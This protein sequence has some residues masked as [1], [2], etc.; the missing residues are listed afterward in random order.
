MADHI[1][2]ELAE[3]YLQR[4]TFFWRNARDANFAKLQHYARSASWKTLAWDWDSLGITKT[5]R[6]IA[7]DL[8]FVPTEVL[9]HPEVIAAKPRLFDYYRMLAC[10]SQKGFAQIR[11]KAPK[12]KNDRTLETCRLLNRFLSTLIAAIGRTNRDTLLGTVY[13]EAGSEWQG[14]WVNII[15]KASAI[16]LERIVTDFAE[17][18]Q[19]LEKANT[20][21]HRLALRSGTTITFGSEPDV[22]CRNVKGELLCVIEIKGSADKAGAQT[23]LGETK[24]SFTKAKLEN[25]R[26]YTIFLPSVLTDAV[27]KQLKTERDIDKVFDLL[28]IFRDPEK[29]TEFLLEFFRF[30]LRETF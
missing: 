16:E 6:K 29:R 4:A 21:Q 26:C 24:K 8:G 13:A 9:A 17:E 28:A 23:R 3:R 2:D 15:G 27:R 30:Q 10:L 19:L 25:P 1:G 5:A 22:E 18:K 7:A 11:D 14:T 20:Q 12:D